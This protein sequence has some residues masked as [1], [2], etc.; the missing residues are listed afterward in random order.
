MGASVPG[1]S[2]SV[3]DSNKY[4]LDFALE[5]KISVQAD[6]NKGKGSYKI[7]GESLSFGPIAL[8][9]MMCPDGSLD[10]QFLQDLSFVRSYSLQNGH[11]FLSLMGNGGTY[12]FAPSGKP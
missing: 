11:L 9:K 5:G 6:C 3:P 10:N 4:I 1:T 7:H 12:E 2:I 8:T